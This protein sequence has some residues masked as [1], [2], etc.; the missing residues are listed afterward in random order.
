MTTTHDK[1]VAVQADLNRVLFE[2]TSAVDH[3]LL[4][5]LTRQHY[6]MLGPPGTGKSLLVDALQARIT[7]ARHFKRVLHPATTPEDLLGP[8]DLIEMADH[9]RYVRRHGRS[10]VEADISFLDEISR[11]NQ[12]VY[13]LLLQILN[14]RVVDEIGL[15]Q[16]LRLPLISVF[17]A[18][19]APLTGN[20]NL[21][22]LNN[23]F[24]L[25]EEIVP[26]AERASRIQLATKPPRLSDVQ[27]QMTL[28]DLAAAQTEAQA[29]R[30]TKEVLSAAL[31]L[32]DALKHDGVSISDRMW[33]WSFPLIKARAWLAGAAEVQL[34][35]LGVLAAAWWTD[36]KEK[37]VVQRA[38][39]G[40]ANPLE[41]LA[42]EYED[43][44]ADLL[45]QM[46][47]EDDPDFLKAGDT[48]QPQLK[49]IVTQLASAIER[50]RARDK[51]KAK[52]SLKTVFLATKRLQDRLQ[53]RMAPDLGALEV[54]VAA[55]LAS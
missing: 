30:M 50:S 35:D 13:D 28:A 33:T 38:I 42:L 47:G 25:R 27:A 12:M 8:I 44:A 37:A 22:A 15:D 5:L 14:E 10:I 55:L 52:A 29:V 16:P 54:D 45:K 46:P 19:N 9:G 48:V 41:M 7:G 6:L 31:D 49:D 4:A 20:D 53:S 40:V 23:R 34:E 18:S 21:Q 11:C 24:L 51:R 1:V 26:I 2:R 3:A 36:T 17:G 32:Q 43:N 39:C